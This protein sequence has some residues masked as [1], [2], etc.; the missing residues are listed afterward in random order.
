MLVCNPL[1]Y[2]K[3]VNY[4]LEFLVFFLNLL[5]FFRLRLPAVL[6][7]FMLHFYLPHLF[8]PHSKLIYEALH[9]CMVLVLVCQLLQSLPLALVELLQ[10]LNLLL[11]L[12]LLIHGVF[13]LFLQG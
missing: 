7:P 3:F 1:F 2:F 13:E 9:F 11:Q 5:N 8:L 4:G 12:Q 6:F 10:I